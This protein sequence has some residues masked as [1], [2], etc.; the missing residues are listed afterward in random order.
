VTFA[1]SGAL[2]FDL[3]EA[4]SLS[5]IFIQADANDVYRLTGSLDGT[6]GSFRAIGELAAVSERG[7]GLRTRTL[8]FAPVTLRFLR[9]S[10]GPGD[11]SYSIAEIA[12]YCALPAPF[13]PAF[14]LVASTSGDVSAKA[15]SGPQ[16][17][18]EPMPEPARLPLLVIAG[19]LSAFGIFGASRASAAKRENGVSASEPPRRSIEPALRLMFFLSGCAALIYEVVWFHLMRL[20]IGASA[21]S[22]GIVLASFMGGMFLGSLL[23]PRYV[24]A[25]RHP[26]R[27][28]AWLELGIGA[29]GLAMPLLLPAIRHVYIGLVGYGSLGIALRSLIAAIMLLPPAA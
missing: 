1:G 2:T 18:L 17:G 7:H 20:V 11:G 4:R 25:A 12:G 10:D 19:L 5:A 9:V 3:G 28:Y 22:V 13:P 21:L 29:F 16:P 14:K 6:P 24:S 27:V 15:A 23:F 26:L 8:Q